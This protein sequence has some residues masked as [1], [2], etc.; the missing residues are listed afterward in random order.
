MRAGARNTTSVVLARVTVAGAEVP[1]RTRA[2]LGSASPVMVTSVPPSVLTRA[3]LSEVILKVPTAGKSTVPPSSGTGPAP[4]APEP[5]SPEPA[6]PEPEPVAPAGAP[7][8]RGAPPRGRR[9]GRGGGAAGAGG[10]GAARAAGGGGPAGVG[11]RA[12]A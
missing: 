1:I 5:P 6:E 8:G 3:G 9:R 2:P 4:G 10:R 11:H 7:A 12:A